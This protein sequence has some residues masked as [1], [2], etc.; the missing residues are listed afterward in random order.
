MIHN[1]SHKLRPNIKQLLFEHRELNRDK[2]HCLLSLLISNINQ[3]ITQLVDCSLVSTDRVV[4]ISILILLEQTGFATLR[5]CA[6]NVTQFLRHLPETAVVVE[7][8]L[9]LL[10]LLG[11]I[12]GYSVDLTR[13]GNSV[14]I[15][16]GALIS[17]D[18]GEEV[19]LVD[20]D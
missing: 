16:S 5:P 1:V 11:D 8:L 2:L 4:L 17:F 7:D 12:V 10:D 14:D 19:F 6:N 18:W 9:D 20:V 13:L 3:V 15:R